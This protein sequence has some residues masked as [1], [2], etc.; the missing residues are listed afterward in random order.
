MALT[1]LEVLEEFIIN[2]LN[3]KLNSKSYSN[4]WGSNFL[5]CVYWSFKIGSSICVRE[6]WLPHT[7][8]PNISSSSSNF[9]ELFILSSIKAP[10]NYIAL[11]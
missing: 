10:T 4:N 6:W 9:I 8:M 7:L 2:I 5:C 3:H 11:F 1:V